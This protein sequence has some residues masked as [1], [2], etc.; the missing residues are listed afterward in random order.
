LPGRAAE[1]GWIR[2]SGLLARTTG[3]NEQ[4]RRQRQR[5]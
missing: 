2:R 5:A 1:S 4:D 3:D